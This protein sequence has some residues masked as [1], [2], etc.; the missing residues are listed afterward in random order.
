MKNK[1]IFWNKWHTIILVLGLILLSFFY[2]PIC[3]MRGS[4]PL[5]SIDKNIYYPSMPSFSECLIQH[6]FDIFPLC[7]IIILYLIV[8]FF[9]LLYYKNKLL[10]RVK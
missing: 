1:K 10:K 6:L 5:S 3:S 9:S 4:V 7:F 2:I 8:T